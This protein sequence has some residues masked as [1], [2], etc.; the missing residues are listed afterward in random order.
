MPRAQDQLKPQAQG[1]LSR[2]ILCNTYI[3]AKESFTCPRCKKGPLCRTHRFSGRRE[4]T[5]CVFDL[6]QREVIALRNQEQ[7][8]ADF[9]KLLQFIFLVFAIFFVAARAGLLEFVDLLKDNIVTTNLAWFGIL[10]VAGYLLFYIILY[11]Q[12]NKIKEI[13]AEMHAMEF[14]RMVK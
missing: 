12:R 14:K 5:S 8:I 3:N 13:E 1:E 4:C 2:C 6:K 10:P 9:T 7:S 11:N